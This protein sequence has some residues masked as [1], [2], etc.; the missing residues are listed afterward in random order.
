MFSSELPGSVLIQVG[1][2]IRNGHFLY[3]CKNLKVKC[4]L[5]RTRAVGIFSIKTVV[6][7]LSR[8]KIT[9]EEYIK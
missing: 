4:S 1:E 3:K 2:S 9:Q 7:I 6:E 8:D 5:D